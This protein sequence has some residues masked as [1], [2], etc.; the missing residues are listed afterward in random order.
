MREQMGVEG[1]GKLSADNLDTYT[2]GKEEEAENEE[3]DEG[4]V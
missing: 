2:Q 4:L 1:V 3:E